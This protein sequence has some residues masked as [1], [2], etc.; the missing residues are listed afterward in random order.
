MKT[1]IQIMVLGLLLAQGPTWAAQQ[2]D[3]TR[4]AN[5][6][7]HVEIDVISGSIRITGWDR[8]EIAIKGT[9]GDDV[10]ALDIS[11][12]EGRISIDL[13]IPENWGNRHK[14]IDVDLEISAPKGSRLEVETNQAL[15]G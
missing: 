11:L 9:V 2:V 13:D 1:L 12:S 8:E 7:A 14:N 5:P 6:D 3:E 15:D 4:P 10:E